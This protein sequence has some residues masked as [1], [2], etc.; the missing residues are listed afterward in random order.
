MIQVA[1]E[2]GMPGIRW[3]VMS[4]NKEARNFYEQVAPTELVPTL[5]QKQ[6]VNLTESDGWMVYRLTGDAMERLATI[7][8]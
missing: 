5:F 6:A 4:W 2:R 8:S 7:D 1:K 3:I